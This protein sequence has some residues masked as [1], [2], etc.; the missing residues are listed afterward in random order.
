MR[1]LITGGGGN[2]G[3]VLAPALKEAG[4]E[5][6]LMDNR[7]LESP[8]ETVRGDA[9][10][11]T[12]VSGAIRGAD[13][14]VHAA[15]LHGIHLDKY[16]ADD[17]WE[18]NVAGTRYVYEAA[19]EH[20][21]GK[22]L[23]CSTMAAYGWEFQG[24][25][26]VVTEDR[27]LLPSDVYGLSK[28]LC[29]EMAAFYARRDGIR[30]VAY[31]LGMFVPESFVQYGFRLLKGG[32]DDRDVAQAFLLGLEDVSISFDAF[33][34]MAAVPFPV[35]E[36]GRFS[37]D[38]EPFL[39]ERFPGLSGLVEEQGADFGKLARMWGF[40]YWSVEKAARA[41]GYAPWYNFPEFFEALRRGDR[42]HYPFADLPWWGV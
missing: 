34:I 22:V 38:P 8:Y 42:S 7:E 4:H 9:R 15:A 1:V 30:T 40:T 3:R 23:L 13:V 14:V 26:P 11:R 39:E 2:L 10:D 21:V 41:L 20:G 16:A 27:P 17:F 32:V 24:D 29:E 33:N 25:P 6:V 19:V 35:E 5:P 12:E 36:F 37:Q 31:R 28:T 18:G